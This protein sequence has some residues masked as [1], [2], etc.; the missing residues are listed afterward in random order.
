MGLRDPKVLV[1][2]ADKNTLWPQILRNQSYVI[3][4][5]V[6]TKIIG[7][8]WENSSFQRKTQNNELINARQRRDTVRISKSLGR[9]LGTKS[10]DSC[11]C[12]YGSW[13]RS[14]RKVARLL[15]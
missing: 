6:T 9:V 5:E 14:T 15:W 12:L 7:R 2:P 8:V 1:C 13:P 4:Y 11:L 3:I 10:T